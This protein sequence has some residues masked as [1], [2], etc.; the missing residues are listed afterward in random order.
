MRRINDIPVSKNFKLR[1]FECHDGSHL[2][3][4]D[5]LLIELLQK[6]RDK[7][8]KPITVTSGYRTPEYNR[9]IG[10]SPNSQHLL[11][12]A[13]DIKVAGV[14]PREVAQLAIKIGFRGIGVY[15]TFVHVD[16]RDRLKNTV[17][18]KY[19]YWEG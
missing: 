9:K 19:D 15:K 8:G 17:G 13:A 3:K 2:V 7:L 1:E 11:G 4:I 10:G 12:K 14:S 6:L 16:V 18:R 5:P